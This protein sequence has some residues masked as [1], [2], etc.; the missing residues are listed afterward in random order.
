MEYLGKVKQNLR[1]LKRLPDNINS[2]SSSLQ[3]Q[4]KSMEYLVN[5]KVKSEK[6]DCLITMPDEKYGISGERE[7][8]SEKPDNMNSSSSSLQCQMKCMEYLGKVKVKREKPNNINSPSSSFKSMEYLG[9]VKVKSE[10]E[11]R[12]A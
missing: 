9:K 2:S 3:W 8:E 10:S 11:K 5:V 7:S 6:P 4:M 12:K 1:W